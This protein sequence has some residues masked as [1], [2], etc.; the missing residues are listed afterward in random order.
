MVSVLMGV[1][2]AVRP[3]RSRECPGIARLDTRFFPYAGLT[4]AQVAYYRRRAPEHVLAAVAAGDVVGFVIAPVVRY[5][6][7][8][9]VHIVSMGVVG[10]WRRRGLGRR[11]LR[12]AIRRGRRAGAGKVRLEVWTGNRAAIAL[13][14]TLGLETA[15]RRPDYYEP[16]R[17]ALVMER[18]IG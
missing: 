18:R 1:P 12:A 2:I 11:L 5:G 3:A 15:R 8:P 4:P 7:T 9:A 17:D 14:R 10:S 13:Y 16:G 6:V